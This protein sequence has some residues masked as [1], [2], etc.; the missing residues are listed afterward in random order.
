[1]RGVPQLAGR[2][3]FNTRMRYLLRPATLGAICALLL[4][5]AAQAQTAQRPDPDS[6]A[7]VEY[8]LP[9]DQA[10]ENAGGGDGAD[11]PAS[12]EGGGRGGRGA[13]A[14]LFGAGIVAAKGADRA[15]GGGEGARRDGGNRAQG[16][17][18]ASGGAAASA[19]GGSDEGDDPAGPQ[20]IKRS[21]LSSPDDEGGSA[22]LRII[23]IALAVL[24]AGAL[25]GLL[26]RRGLRDSGN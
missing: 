14:P 18:E 3:R 11:D 21:G 6:P 9:L 10:R 25:L 17:G 15:I 5:A 2:N 20:R 4:P 16:A 8:Q 1:M 26:L 7:G 13:P 22:T 23:G 24:L 12:R 19:S